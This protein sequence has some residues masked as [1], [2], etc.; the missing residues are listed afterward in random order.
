MLVGNPIDFLQAFK[1]IENVYF[2]IALASADMVMKF[3][4]KI[5]HKRTLFGSD[6]P[7]GTME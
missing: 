1:A 3:I 7:F 5:G 6:T 2:D 4:E